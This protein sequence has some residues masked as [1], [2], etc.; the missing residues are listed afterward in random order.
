MLPTPV[1]KVIGSLV[2]VLLLIAAVLGW[3]HSVKQDGFREGAA[4]VQAKWDADTKDY[5]AEIN[6][7][8]GEAAVLEAN[9]RTENT[10]ITHELAEAN[11]KHAVE[12][13]TLQF[14]FDRRLQLSSKR[15]VV[16]QRQS[17]GGA[18]ECRDLA[19]HASRLDTALEEGR[20]LEQEYRSTLGLRDRQIEALSNQIRNDRTLMEN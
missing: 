5:D 6:R 2:L 7:L 4:S 11:R 9:H 10:R 20:A 3:R 14:D 19:S 18:A 1:I 17:E 16:Y 12:V 8:K 15:S 13:A